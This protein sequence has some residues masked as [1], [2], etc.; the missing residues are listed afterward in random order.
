MVIIDNLWLKINELLSLVFGT[1]F[2]LFERLLIVGT[3]TGVIVYFIGKM[4]GE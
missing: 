1:N 2:T 4:K 3:C